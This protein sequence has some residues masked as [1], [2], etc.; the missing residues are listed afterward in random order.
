MNLVI[1]TNVEK[2]HTLCHMLQ[3]ILAKIIS[4]QKSKTA[5]MIIIVLEL[6]RCIFSLL[7]CSF[8]LQIHVSFH[9]TAATK[10]YMLGPPSGEG[11]RHILN[12]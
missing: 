3:T 4:S 6:F 8:I 7:S 11:E 5:A 10:L 9:K 2:Y 12:I 1:V